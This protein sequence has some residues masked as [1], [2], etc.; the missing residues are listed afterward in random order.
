MKELRKKCE[1][2]IRAG[3]KFQFKHD[4]H[5]ILQLLDRLQAQTDEIER[6][7]DSPFS[8]EAYE[9]LQGENRMLKAKLDAATKVPLADEP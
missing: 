3:S 1:A 5:E 7:K 8:E 2:I 4:P 9:I 6:L